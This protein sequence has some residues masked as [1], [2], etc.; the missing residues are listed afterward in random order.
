MCG[1]LASVHILCSTFVTTVVL[2]QWW[3][4]A[5]RRRELSGA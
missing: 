3:A 2:Q 1:A 4:S 5:A